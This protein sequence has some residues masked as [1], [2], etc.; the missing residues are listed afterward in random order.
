[1]ICKNCGHENEKN[2]K[3]CEKCG[4]K[5]EEIKPEIIEEKKDTKVCPKCGFANDKDSK[6]CQS[7]GSKLENIKPAIIEEKKDSKAC[8]KCGFENDKESKFCESCGSKLDEAKEEK[9]QT[10][11]VNKE[12]L[13]ELIGKNRENSQEKNLGQEVKK[14]ENKENPQK[15]AHKA[16]EDSYI[17]I[18]KR[19]DTERLG[20]DFKKDLNK[21][22]GENRRAKRH[23][24]AQEEKF[25]EENEKKNVLVYALIAGFCLIVLTVVIAVGFF[26][27]KKSQKPAYKQNQEIESTENSSYQDLYDQAL[28]AFYNEDYNEAA[29]KFKSIPQEEVDLYTKAQK[30]LSQIE[31]RL[32]NDLNSYIED[33]DYNTAKSLAASYLKII[34]NSKKIKDIYNQLESGK[35][36]DSEARNESDLEKSK[37]YDL[38]EIRKNNSYGEG[39]NPQYTEIYKPEDFLNKSFRIDTD[40][41]KVRAN[42]DMNSEKIGD[43]YRGEIYHVY[44]VKSDGERYWLNI[45]D[46]A[47]ISSKLITGEYRD[48]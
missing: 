16:S 48:K 12:R 29:E 39:G 2:S 25:S 43:V 34:P 8:P 47:W 37:D 35:I 21:E 28:D 24:R 14:A 1:M 9:G 4:S 40:S 30:N 32:V 15:A 22:L 6:F 36:E 45:G 23:E 11:L 3:F 42:A 27:S 31:K 13:E 38:E 33:E 46:N 17:E 26:G 44:D 5:L 10:T 19:R 18:K 20:Q 41:G 7:C